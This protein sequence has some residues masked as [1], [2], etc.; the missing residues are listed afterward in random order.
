MSEGLPFGLSHVDS[1]LADALR[2]GLD[3]VEVALR[4]AVASDYPFVDETASHLV[5]AGG[6][7]FRPLL[8]LVAAQYGDPAAAG[9]V[10]AAVV[11]ELTHLAT[12]YHDDVMDEAPLRRGAP[13]ANARWDNTVAILTGD[14]LFARA[15]DIAVRPRHRDR[16]AAGAHVRAALHRSD[17]RDRR[18][19]RGRGR[20][21]APPRRPRPTRP[22]RSSR[23]PVGWVR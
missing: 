17:P 14:F 11:V 16:P 8:A 12:L 23:W 2:A 7:R 13:S 19:G 1:A 10:P 4:K 22:A 20:R 15:A 21:R 6:K 9:V 5:N 3:D 18:P